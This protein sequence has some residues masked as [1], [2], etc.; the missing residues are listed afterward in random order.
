MPL[1]FMPPAVGA[2][3]RSFAREDE[4]RGSEESKQEGSSDTATK[5]GA[6][7][8]ACAPATLHPDQFIEI[9]ISG[10]FFLK[11]VSSCVVGKR[12]IL[13]FPRKCVSVPP[14]ALHC[15]ALVLHR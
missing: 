14:G 15:V 2:A 9:T 4:E 11:E 6:D 1:S 12:S 13:W 5:D 10:S 8:S 3:K 7:R